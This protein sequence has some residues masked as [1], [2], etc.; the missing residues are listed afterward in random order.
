[1]IR[2]EMAGGRPVWV[3]WLSVAGLS[4]ATTAIL[5]AP[6][7]LWMLGLGERTF[8]VVSSALWFGL[9]IVTGII[10]PVA[11]VAFVIA[12]AQRPR[13]G[14]FLCGFSAL[15]LVSVLCLG[16]IDSWTFDQALQRCA[17]RGTPLLIAIREYEH[18]NGKLPVCVNDLVPRFIPEVPSTGFGSP[19]VYRYETAAQVGSHGGPR[20]PQWWVRVTIPTRFAFD[21]PELIA[22]SNGVD[23]PNLG[24]GVQD[25]RV[26][27]WVLYR[28]PG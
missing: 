11:V 1:M 20:S 5:A 13:A 16:P 17:D 14:A 21:G 24:Y 27:Q 19:F 12:P 7:F 2:E 6:H 4:A 28:N 8:G 9:W 10:A 3:L 26:G 25:R 22:S 15:I 23:P 18:A